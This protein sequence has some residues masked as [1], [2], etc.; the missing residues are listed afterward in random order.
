MRPAPTRGALPTALW[1]LREGL[2]PIPIRPREKRP[3]GKSWGASY[4]SRDKLLTAYERCRGAGV[5]V[6]LG[7]GA[8]LVDFEIDA[9]GEAAALLERLKLP[10]TLGWQSARGEHRLFLWD[11]RLEGLIG[12]AVT[13]LDGAELRAGGDVKQLVSVCPPSVG[14]DGRRRRWLDI[15]EIATLPESLLRELEQRKDPPRPR[16]PVVIPI[17]TSRYGEAALRYESR[18]VAEAQPGTRNRTLVRAAFK[19][20]QLVAVGALSREAVELGLIEAA[21][22]AGLGEREVTATIKSGLEAG[23]ARPRDVQRR[24]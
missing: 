23:L 11:E 7:P 18:A 8:G 24:R 3:I 13:H 5:G 21:R 1:M 12:S 15:W 22:S 14:T 19:L 16:K 4:P 2:W 9:P 6:A 10:P 20:G 17:G